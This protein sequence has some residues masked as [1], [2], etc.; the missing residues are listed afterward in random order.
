MAGSS[1]PKLTHSDSSLSLRTRKNN[2]D[3]RALAVENL[4][5]KASHSVDERVFGE[6]E[7]SHGE[8]QENDGLLSEVI[9]MGTPDFN[10]ENWNKRKEPKKWLSAINL[11]KV[12]LLLLLCVALDTD[13][14]M[15]SEIYTVLYSYYYYDRF[16]WCRN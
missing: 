13:D 1:S 6:A 15:C 4:S 16:L 8:F 3:V 11:I 12:S 5:R 9:E 14:D 7:A 2:N 10:D